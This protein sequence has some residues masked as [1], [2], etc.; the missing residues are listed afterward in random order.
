VTSSATWV[1]T[2]WA[3]SGSPAAPVTPAPTQ[4]CWPPDSPAAPNRNYVSDGK[5][6]DCS[7]QTTPATTAHAPPGTRSRRPGERCPATRG[8]P[9]LG[10][11]VTGRRDLGRELTGRPGHRPDARRRPRPT[12]SPSPRRHDPPL[13]SHRALHTEKLVND[14]G[15]ASVP[16]STRTDIWMS[17]YI[18]LVAS[19]ERRLTP[20]YSACQRVQR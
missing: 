8:P 16:C 9:R 11:P 13:P 12:S 4:R 19:P 17:G 20:G 3:C 2:R 10:R 6:L 5:P 1:T 15:S 18:E 14:P 7:E